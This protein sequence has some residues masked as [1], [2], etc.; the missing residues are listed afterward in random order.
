MLGQVIYEITLFNYVQMHADSCLTD[1]K[2]KKI[3]NSYYRCSDSVVS[4]RIAYRT[5]PTV[6]P[7]LFSKEQAS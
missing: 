7:R 2:R 5:L 1:E 4:I 6:L 3:S